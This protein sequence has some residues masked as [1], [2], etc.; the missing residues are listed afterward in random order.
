MVQGAE[1]R[2]KGRGALLKY[3]GEWSVCNTDTTTISEM[4]QVYSLL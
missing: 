3:R 2:D 4:Q 1:G